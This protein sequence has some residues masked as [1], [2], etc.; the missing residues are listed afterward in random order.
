MA[1]AADGLALFPHRAFPRGVERA[2]TGLLCVCACVWPCGLTSVRVPCECVPCVTRTHGVH[3]PPTPLCV[4]AGAKAL[5]EWELGF[6]SPV[7]QARQPW[8]SRLG[9]GLTFPVIPGG[10]PPESPRPVYLGPCNPS[11]PGLPR[12]G[13]RSPS[14]PCQ[15]SPGPFCKERVSLPRGPGVPSSRPSGKGL[16]RDGQRPWECGE[17]RPPPLCP[18]LPGRPG[19]GTLG[20]LKTAPRV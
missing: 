7:P 9:L 19:E 10:L 14:G 17:G 12:E 5:T 13:S 20:R 4:H 16:S 3:F 11:A 2:V 6:G 18:R 1:G 15:A 8:C